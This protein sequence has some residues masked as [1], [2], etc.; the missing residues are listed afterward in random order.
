M[1]DKEEIEF[2]RNDSAAA[3]NK[4]E[5]RRIAEHAAIRRADRAEAVL[6]TIQ[7]IIAANQSEAA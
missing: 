3:W 4:C 6:Q 2:W 1:N 5:E 7:R